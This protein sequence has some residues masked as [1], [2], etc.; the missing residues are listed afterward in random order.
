MKINN[1]TK[2]EQKILN[3]LADF[4]N[5]NF[6][7]SEISKKIKISL[8][9]CHNAL[10]NLKKKDMVKIELR[11]NMK[12]WQI[13]YDNILLKQYRIPFLL[14][15]LNDFIKELK[16]FC[17]QII[18]FGSSARG[19]YNRNSDIDIVLITSNKQD[20]KDLINKYSKKYLIKPIIKT[21]NEWHEL[22]SK[23]PEFFQEVKSGIEL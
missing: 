6:F 21:S 23:E 11:G 10:K 17:Q 19:E 14:D 15:R 9:G 8:G 13:N 2:N 3:L 12:F 5:D 7:T 20:V 16:P 22:E 18:L 4:P 1:L